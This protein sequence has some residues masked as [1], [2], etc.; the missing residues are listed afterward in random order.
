MYIFIF[1]PVLESGVLISIGSLAVY[2]CERVPKHKAHIPVLQ[3]TVG[4]STAP[5]SRGLGV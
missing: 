3:H 5:A 2:N 1:E 4:G